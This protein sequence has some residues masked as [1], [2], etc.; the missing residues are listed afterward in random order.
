MVSEA[1]R[2]LRK[3]LEREVVDP[4]KSLAEARAEWI[5]AAADLELSK[6]CQAIGEKIAGVPCLWLRPADVVNDQLVL[7]AHGGGLISGSALTHRA[8]ASH[9]ATAIGRQLLLVDYRLV[10][11]H[12]FSAPRDDFTAVYRNL[13]GSARFKARDIAMAGDS[14]GAGVIIASMIS[15]REA[16]EIGP[17]AAVCLSG[18]FDVS[19]S[20]E[21]LT[22][23]AHLDPLLSAEVLLDWQSTFRGKIALDDPI[24][25]P[26]FGV[27]R[28]LAPML[29]LVGDHELWL[30]DSTRLAE[31]LQDSGCHVKLHIYEEMWHVWPMY[32]ELPETDLAML[33]IRHF[34]DQLSG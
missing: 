26:L 14:N 13:V 30:S 15:L 11:E 18:A 5:D 17:S 21:S 10:P 16:G 23:R 32:S 25:S 27:L 4:G 24:I 28:G 1:S 33:E 34:L 8:F 22:S 3:G 19:L 9:L 7:Y 2:Q 12:P 6:G 20:G 29:L 31:K